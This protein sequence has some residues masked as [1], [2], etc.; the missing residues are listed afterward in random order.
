M[1]VLHFGPHRGS[2]QAGQSLTLYVPGLA[3]DM[4]SHQE[5]SGPRHDHECQVWEEVK[6]PE[7]KVLLVVASTAKHNLR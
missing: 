1:V 2:T 5:A 7:G 6:V 3:V 4:L